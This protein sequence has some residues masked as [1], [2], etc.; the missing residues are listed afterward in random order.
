MHVGFHDVQAASELVQGE[1]TPFAISPEASHGGQA[2]RTR[3]DPSEDEQSVQDSP[4]MGS[5]ASP[6]Q[7]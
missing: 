3:Q 6:S 1:A 4:A 7:Q 2:S 5:V